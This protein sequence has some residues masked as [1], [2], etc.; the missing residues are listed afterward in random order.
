[1]PKFPALLQQRQVVLEVRDCLDDELSAYF[2]TYYYGQFFENYYSKLSP[3]Q[4]QQSPLDLEREIRSRYSMQRYLTLRSITTK[5]TDYSQPGCCLCFVL[6]CRVTGVVLGLAILGPDRDSTFKDA[7]LEGCYYLHYLCSVSGVMNRSFHQTEPGGLEK[8]YWGN[9]IDTLLIMIIYFYT[10]KFGKGFFLQPTAA[11]EFYRNLGLQK[12][13]VDPLSVF[14]SPVGAEYRR[15]LSD[16]IN[17]MLRAYRVV[18]ELMANSDQF[19]MTPAQAY[20]D[21]KKSVI[22]QHISSIVA[23]QRLLRV[24]QDLLK[25]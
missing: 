3:L 11:N 14:R 16:K 9:G 25:K 20:L 15:M 18:P 5:P 8:N 23:M 6:R 12:I 22:S 17:E 13:E 19:E 1:M 21:N 2:N 4:T 10:T 24:R 7:E